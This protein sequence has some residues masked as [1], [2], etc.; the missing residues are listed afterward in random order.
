MKRE[1]GSAAA[2][3]LSVTLLNLSA[4]AEEKLDRITGDFEAFVVARGLQSPD[5]LAIHPVTHELYVSEESAG[6]ISVIRNGKAIPVIDKKI[7]IIDD[8]PSWAIGPGREKKIW[9]R[10][11]LSSPEGIAF[12]KAGHLF[13]VED[14]ADGRVLEFKPD[15]DGR[16]GSAHVIP[17]PLASGSYAWESVTVAGDG[18]IFVAGSELENASRVPTL[19]S[20]GVFMRDSASDWWIVDCGPLAGFSAVGLSR[21]EDILVVGEEAVGGVTCW[22][23]VR[24]CAMADV[25]KTIKNI[26]GLA[27]LPDGAIVVAQES[28]PADGK[29]AEPS[30]QPGLVAGRLLRVDPTSAEVSSIAEGFSTIESVIVD[31]ETH[32]L[33]VSEDGTGLLIELRPSKKFASNEYLLQRTVQVAEA[34]Q[35]LAPR[36]APP[37][38]KDFFKRVGVG[39]RDQTASDLSMPRRSRSAPG[40]SK[41]L[42]LEELGANIPM[43]AGKVKMDPKQTANQTDPIVEIQFIQ[44][45]PGLAL[46]ADSFASPGLSLYAAKHQ[47]GR[48]ERTQPLMGLVADQFVGG[49]KVR[50]FG[51]AFLC[52]PLVSCS[53]AQDQDGVN[54]ALAIL[55]LDTAPD[56]YLTLKVGKKNSGVLMIDG[57]EGPLL[58]TEASILDTAIDG[59]EVV[60][61]FMTGVM[62]RRLDGGARWLKIGN[63]EYWTLVLP[64]GNMW[65]SHWINMHMPQLVAVLNSKP[66][67][68]HIALEPKSSMEKEASTSE[69]RPPTAKSKGKAEE[70]IHEAGVQ[71]DLQPTA[72]TTDEE[73]DRPVT[74]TAG[75]TQADPLAMSTDIDAC[76]TN[77]VLSRVLAA[78]GNQSF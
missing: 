57:D 17:V 40:A 4:P 24:Q 11:E 44:M 3:I 26:E 37:F 58:S 21:D 63:H 34:K 59:T 1:W 8:V 2:V 55:N 41:D 20:G 39:I 65:I 25:S 27:I 31:S 72:R 61:V 19:V 16:Y 69:G 52:L 13:V 38:I 60:N 9:M 70:R 48:I 7:T 22:D 64:E 75:N 5:G 33:Y 35:G 77:M 50:H 56:L 10:G 76:L 18:R 67:D 36:K 78:W 32:S 23:A 68:E 30:K 15:A 49:K 54:M 71:R 14:A 47:S 62:P 12:S 51:G 6:R 42:T 43:I 66:A 74:P 53:A 45:F 73:D 29:V 28:A 46:F